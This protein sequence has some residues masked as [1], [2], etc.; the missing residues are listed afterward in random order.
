MFL[1]RLENI[2]K[3]KLASFSSCSYF[4][5]T[6]YDISKSMYQTSPQP[7]KKKKNEMGVEVEE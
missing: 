2:L 5:G 4:G 6:Y 3:N 7:K 1:H